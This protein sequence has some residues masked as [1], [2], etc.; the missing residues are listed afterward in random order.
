MKDYLLFV[1]FPYVS[2]AVMLVVSWLRYV[3]FRHQFT[4]LSSEFLESKEL[5]WGSVPWHYGILFVLLGHLVAFMFPREILVWNQIPLRLLILEVTALVFG[6]MALV[7]IILL[8]IRRVTHPRIR[9]VTSTMDIV[10]LLVLLLQVATGVGIAVFYR[11]GSSWY[12]ASLVPYLRSLFVFKPNVEYIVGM[13]LLIKIHVLSAFS[14]I[15]LLS[16]TRLIHFLVIPINYLWRPYQ[17]V[18]WN[19]DRKKIRK[20]PRSQ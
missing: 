20:A 1:V 12:A 19:W 4:S 5:F 6:L 10:V 17:L 3:Y 11:W 18:I 8:I 7:G 2:V 9:H 15:G 14:I 16:F 13:P